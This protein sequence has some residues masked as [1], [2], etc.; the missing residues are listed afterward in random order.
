MFAFG[1]SLLFVGLIAAIVN[2]AVTEEKFN[3]G[4]GK[5]SLMM[6]MMAFMIGGF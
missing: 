6:A 1:I 3:N 2:M 5:A 4:W